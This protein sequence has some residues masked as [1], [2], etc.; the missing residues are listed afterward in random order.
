[1]NLKLNVLLVTRCSVFTA[2]LFGI[3]VSV[4]LRNGTTD[5]RLTAFFLRQAILANSI[6]YLSLLYMGSIQR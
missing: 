5:S 3:A 1:M 2:E 4:S 6:K